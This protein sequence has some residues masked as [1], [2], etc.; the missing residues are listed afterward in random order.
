MG[1]RDYSPGLNRFLTRDSYNGA[2]SDL[3]LG[4]N[5]WTSNRYAFAGGNPITN[6]ELD[7]HSWDEFLDNLGGFVGGIKDGAVD[8]ANGLGQLSYDVFI[9]SSPFVSE[10]TRQETHARAQ[11]RGDLIKHPGQL[12][13]ALLQPYKD[14]I[15]Q[16]DDARAAGRAV[17]DISTLL[18]G[19]GASKVGGASKAAE[20][21]RAADTVAITAERPVIFTDP[22]KGASAAQVAQ[23]RAYTKICNEAYCAGALSSTG[24]VSTK[25]AL[26][27]AKDA[28]AKAEKKANP[29]KY[30]TGVQPGHGPDTTWT[31]NPQPYAWIPLDAS[32][33][34]SL[35]SQALRYPLG[36]KPTGFW[37]IDDF[38]AEFGKLP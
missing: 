12:V 31:G 21:A 25:G 19:G 38:L 27:V 20:A 18:L 5:P 34:Q 28:A 23:I 2:L 29:T 3:N 7:G 9:G 35:G 22:V 24:R 14:D 32:I 1:F 33:N 16:G 17:F 8:A 13:D 30:P 4:L 11:A 26:G 10:Q 15:A 6:V 37:Y 36:Y